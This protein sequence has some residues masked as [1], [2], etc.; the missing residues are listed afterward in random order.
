MQRTTDPGTR[1]PGLLSWRRALPAAAIAGLALLSTA[2]P[3]GATTSQPTIPG[4]PDYCLSVNGC[5]V[6]KPPPVVFPC[7]YGGRSEKCC[8][9]WSSG[10]PF[11]NQVLADCPPWFPPFPLIF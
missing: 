11:W 2:S 9:L 6:P 5:P 10:Y 3:A 4:M 8:P 7:W 1:R